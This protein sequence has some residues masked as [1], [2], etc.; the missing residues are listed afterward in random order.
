MHGAAAVARSLGFSQGGFAPWTWTHIQLEFGALASRA[1][2]T[3]VQAECLK[4]PECV[5]SLRGY[6]G[7][8]V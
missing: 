7:Y 5:T 2:M 4:G 3:P 1:L 6:R 8:K